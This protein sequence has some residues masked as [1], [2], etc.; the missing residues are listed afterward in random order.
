VG[1]DR[2]EDRVI[3]DLTSPVCGSTRCDSFFKRHEGGEPRVDHAQR[4]FR[5]FDACHRAK[6]AWPTGLDA[7]DEFN[8]EELLNDVDFRSK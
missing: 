2:S 7:E 6:P 4:C 1:P 5:K 3:V 8:L